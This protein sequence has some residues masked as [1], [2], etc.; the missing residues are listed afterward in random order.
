M[1]RPSYTTQF[2][3]HGGTYVI[4]PY[5]T[6]ER[7]QAFYAAWRYF[8]SQPDKKLFKASVGSLDGYF[9]KGVESAKGY[10]TP[11]PKEF[12]HFYRHGRCPDYCYT[13]SASIF[14]YLA[15][16]AVHVFDEL[17]HE[18]P[19]LQGFTANL[20]KSYR[21][22][23]RIAYYESNVD[24]RYFA[25]PHED[26]N[27]LTL[28]PNATSPGLEVLKPDGLWAPV[29]T[30]DQLCTVLAGDMLTEA[31]GGRIPATR[32]CVK[33]ST[34]ERLS[35]SF[36]LNPDDYTVLSPRWTAGEFL[37]DRLRTIG[38]TAN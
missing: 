33:A 15:E 2:L 29:Q 4:T 16:T 32:H 24:A 17:A 38:I 6:A 27:F 25:A 21:L 9:P 37:R 31:S 5:L 18:V 30:R 22:V 10:D 8:F 26:I 34:R 35:L 3:E 36:F 20:A 23:M 14:E 12:F 19:M 1:R 11:D 7:M 28:L 13:S